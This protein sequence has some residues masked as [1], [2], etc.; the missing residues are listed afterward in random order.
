MI[1]LVLEKVSLSLKGD[2]FVWE[3]DIHSVADKTAFMCVAVN[4]SALQIIY[5][6]KSFD[7]KKDRPISL[8]L[9]AN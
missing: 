2:R 9:C 3:R 6:D 7:Q 8:D 5:K 1:S 4:S